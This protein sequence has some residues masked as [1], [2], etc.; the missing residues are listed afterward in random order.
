MFGQPNKNGQANYTGGWRGKPCDN[1]TQSAPNISD[2]NTNAQK[3][4]LL[5]TAPPSGLAGKADAS[6]LDGHNPLGSAAFASAV[7]PNAV[8]Q[9]Q[10]C[11]TLQAAPLLGSPTPPR[12]KIQ[13]LCSHS[14]YS[15]VLRT[16]TPRSNPL[17]TVVLHPAYYTLC[18][19]YCT[20]RT[21]P[22]CSVHCVLHDP[23]R[24]DPY[25]SCVLDRFWQRGLLFVC[26][27]D[28]DK[29][30]GRWWRILLS[31]ELGRCFELVERG[32][33]TA[34]FHCL[35]HTHTKGFRWSHFAWT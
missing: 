1:I 32:R 18:T 29:L 26:K 35:E 33:G 31:F 15:R 4:Y 14:S 3:A 23:P 19:V 28:I 20:L 9:L 21:I 12:S 5:T 2:F 34:A 7:C 24:G 16:M 25:C 11:S 27:C 30:S 10:V 8:N 22:G 13:K 17:R 6:A